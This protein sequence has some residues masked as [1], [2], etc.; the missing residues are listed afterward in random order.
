MNLVF[1]Y[2]GTIH[3]TI[4]I[5]APA[6]RAA[7]G[8][9]VE[10]GLVADREFSDEE[11]GR[12]LGF[13]AK[14]MWELF[15]PGLT[16]D[17]RNA[18]SRIVG[19]EMIRMIEAGESRLY[20]GILDTLARLK[21]EGYRILFL[22]NCRHA[23]MQAHRKAYDL[24]RFYSDYYC[25]ED[26]DW[27]PKEEIFKDIQKKYEGDFINIGDRFHDIEVARVHGN[28]SI[29]CLYGYGEEGELSQAIEFANSPSD[30]YPLIK[31]I[32]G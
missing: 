23:Y 15:A 24:D 14:E 21:E 27:I 6:F 30:L 1:D 31:K 13:S 28:A 22:S 19:S 18:A 10:Q 17:A 5:Y 8:S 16:D 9:L 26:Y 7:Y 4:H 3:E 32:S 2:D 29:G 25:A 20:P 11:I 12:W